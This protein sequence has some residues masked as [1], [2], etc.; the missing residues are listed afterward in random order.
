MIAR[1]VP[2]RIR[3]A[4][5]LGVLAV[6]SSLPGCATRLS[7]SP[8]VETGDERLVSDVVDDFTEACQNARKA[9]PLF[10]RGAMPQKAE[11]KKYGRFSYWPSVE[12]ARIEGETAAMKVAVRDEKAGKEA[13]E[14]E[15][16]FVKESSGWK[17]QSAPLP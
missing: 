8:V 3:V 2:F 9:A 12:K 4:L 13:G 16:A 6:A 11:F 15:W 7:S 5:A 10:A 17:I 1:T 14:V